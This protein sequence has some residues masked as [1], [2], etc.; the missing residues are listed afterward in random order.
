[1]LDINNDGWLD[2]YVSKA[3]SLNDDNGRRNKLFVNQEDGSFKEE[4]RK[5]GLDDPGYTTQAYSL[6]YDKDGDLDIYVVNYRPDFKNNT[7]IS[8]VIQS[9]ICRS[10]Q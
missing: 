7:K 1:M 8:G 3:G 9:Q 2:I 6:D 10:K 5:W 4:A